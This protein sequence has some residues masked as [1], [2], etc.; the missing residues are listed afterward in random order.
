[1][2]YAVRVIKLLVDTQN[3]DRYEGEFF[4]G[5]KVKGKM[6]EKGG[7]IYEGEYKEDIKVSSFHSLTRRVE[8]EFIQ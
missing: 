1:M 5:R 8:L 4:D 6:T 7:N 3:G 2:K